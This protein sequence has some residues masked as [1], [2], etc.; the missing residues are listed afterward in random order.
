MV[1]A[2]PLR[3]QCTRLL[4][5]C[6]Q[7]TASKIASAVRPLTVVLALDQVAQCLLVLRTD[8]R[9]VALHKAEQRLLPDHGQLA[10][11]GLE[12]QEVVHLGRAGGSGARGVSRREQTP[13]RWARC[14]GALQNNTCTRAAPPPNSGNQRLERVRSICT[15]MVPPQLTS[16]STTRY[17]SAYF[18]SSSTR[19]KKELVPLYGISAGWRTRG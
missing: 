18:L 4:R 3:C 9:L 11:L 6:E 13:N 2:P 14:A 10:L 12:A 17:G 5:C 15:T 1:A 8:L 19:R 7:P 16:A